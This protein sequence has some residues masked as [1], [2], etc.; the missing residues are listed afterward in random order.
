MLGLV[1]RFVAGVL[2]AGTKSVAAGKTKRAT[3]RGRIIGRRSIGT[4]LEFACVQSHVE[5]W[6]GLVVTANL[7]VS[8][9]RLILYIEWH[10][11]TKL[12]MCFLLILPIGVGQFVFTRWISW[13]RLLPRLLFPLPGLFPPLLFLL[14]NPPMLVSDLLVERLQPSQHHWT[15]RWE[16]RYHIVRADLSF[17]FDHHHVQRSRLWPHPDH[18]SLIV[19]CLQYWLHVLVRLQLKWLKDRML[20]EIFVQPDSRRFLH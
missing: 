11:F 2:F 20:L 12:L 5:C 15:H 19:L 7:V 4:V 16:R 1:L 3:K 8:L 9:L 13:W 17:L 18:S 10:Q 14:V 6:K